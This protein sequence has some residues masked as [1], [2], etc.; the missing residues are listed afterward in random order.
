[1]ASPP[2]HS[3]SLESQRLY[4]VVEN[5]HS[6]LTFADSYLMNTEIFFNVDCE[7]WPLINKIKTYIP[8]FNEKKVNAIEQFTCKQT[9]FQILNYTHVSI[10][11][12]RD[13]C[14]LIDNKHLP[15]TED[16]YHRYATNNTRFGPVNC[17]LILIGLSNDIMLLFSKEFSKSVINIIRLEYNTHKRFWFN[18]ARAVSDI[19]VLYSESD[20]EDSFK[21]ESSANPARSPSSYEYSN[22]TLLFSEEEAPFVLTKKPTSHPQ[23]HSKGGCIIA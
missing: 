16:S 5:H 12:D 23:T 2:T 8:D 7:I 20:A 18:A 1:M 11:F 19:F 13:S 4:T 9:Q 3:K 22:P 17:Q 14:L 6:S 21:G 10:G 15:F